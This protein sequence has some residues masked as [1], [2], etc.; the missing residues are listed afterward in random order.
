MAVQELQTGQLPE[1][2]TWTVD[3]YHSTV[4]F[5]VKHHAVGTYRARFAEV[6]GQ[7]DAETRTLTGTAKTESINT[8]ELIKPTL[9]GEEFFDAAKHPEITFVSTSIK[10]D[11]GKLEVEGDLTLKGVTKRITATGTVAGP[12]KIRGWQDAPPRNCIGIDLEATIDRRDFGVEYQ[13][14]LLDGQLSV[15]WNVTIEVALELTAEAED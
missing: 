14:T 10:E 3:P 11:N 9:L 13:N 1:T 8:F 7:Y 12:S 2:R 4:G 15:T 6:T 5:R